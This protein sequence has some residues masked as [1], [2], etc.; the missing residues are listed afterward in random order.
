MAADAHRPAIL[1]D[2]DLVGVGDGAHPLGDDEHGAAR[3]LLAQGPAQGRVGLKVQGGEAVVE[4]VQVSPL[5]QGPGDGQPLLLAPGEVPAP[6]LHPGLESPGQ[7]VH[8]AR[9][10]HRQGVAEVL[11]PRLGVAV[12]EVLRHRPGEE[13]GLLGH[14]GDPLAQVLLP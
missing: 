13:P 1:Q 9:L 2:N 6:L 5:G 8:K 11:L 3:H 7:A 4:N 14:I 10:G 12:A